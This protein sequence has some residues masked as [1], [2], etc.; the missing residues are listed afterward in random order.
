MKWVPM[1]GESS[2]RMRFHKN[3]FW[4]LSKLVSI[5]FIESYP[6]TYGYIEELL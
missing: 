6:K 5:A 2:N 1:E 3:F 4:Y